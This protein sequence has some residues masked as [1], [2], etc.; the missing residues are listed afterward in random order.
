M[1]GLS[2]ELLSIAVPFERSYEE[3]NTSFIICLEQKWLVIVKRA[4]V[5]TR[6]I[7][8][9]YRGCSISYARLSVSSFGQVKKITLID[10]KRLNKI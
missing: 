2:G 7:K 8:R 3:E 5:L 1:N 6:L 4:D 10:L 9:L